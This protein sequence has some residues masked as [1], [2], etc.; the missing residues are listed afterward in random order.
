MRSTWIADSQFYRTNRYIG[1]LS[2]GR[3]AIAYLREEYE[4]ESKK[5]K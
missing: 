4:K 5:D 2:V 1:E 3:P